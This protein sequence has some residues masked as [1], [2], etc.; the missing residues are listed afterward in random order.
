MGNCLEKLK[1]KKDHVR[2]HV[3]SHEIIEVDED[4]EMQISSIS[5]KTKVKVKSQSSKIESKKYKPEIEQTLL[6]GGE[7]HDAL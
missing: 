3:K 7:T 4:L 2:M 5:S 1:R 6:D